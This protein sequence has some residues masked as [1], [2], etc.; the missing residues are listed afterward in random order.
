MSVK[1]LAYTRRPLTLTPWLLRI[2]QSLGERSIHVDFAFG[3]DGEDTASLLRR[4]VGYHGA[5]VTVRNEPSDVDTTLLAG[6][7]PTI[8]AIFEDNISSGRVRELS[9]PT[10]I[11]GADLCLHSE[12]SPDEA[13]AQLFALFRRSSMITET[14]AADMVTFGGGL[15]R[16]IPGERVVT[17]VETGREARLSRCQAIFLGQLCS[18]PKKPVVSKELLDVKI[19]GNKTG[20]R[21]DTLAYSMNVKFMRTQDGLTQNVVYAVRDEGYR[22]LP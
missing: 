6:R 5:M 13:R 7:V 21:L 10:L 8:V 2:L 22:V 14:K 11:A 17:N 20:R 1:L 12:Q 3:A 19:H 16:V 9:V 4:F 15:F 18:D